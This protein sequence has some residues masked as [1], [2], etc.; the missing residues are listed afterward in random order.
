MFAKV[1]FTLTA[2]RPKGTN[3][4][5]PY[6]FDPVSL[7][8]FIRKTRLDNGW[9]IGEAGEMIGTSTLNIGNWESNRNEV[10]LEFR[11]RVYA[12]IGLCP[13]DASF[14]TVERLKERREYFGLTIK[15]LAEILEVDPNTVSA[16]ERRICKPGRKGLM[17]INQFLRCYRA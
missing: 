3:R 12:F 14:T 7:G 17:K 15:K 8:D 2:K 16:W 4:K 10:S 9:D 11:P 5:K 1:P 13:Y 6:P